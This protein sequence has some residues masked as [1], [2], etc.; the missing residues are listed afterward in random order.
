MGKKLGVMSGHKFDPENAKRLDHPERRAM[1]APERVI[2][3]IRPE[4][5]Q[6]WAEIGCGNGFF[7]GPLAAKARKVHALDISEEMLDKLRTNLTEWGV[8]NVEPA[9]SA[10]NTLPLPDDSVDGVLMAFVAHEF[11]ELVKAF[12]EAG[13]VLKPAGTLAVVEF[14]K[15]E[16][17]GPPLEHR[18][19]PEEVEDWARR[20]GLV[21][22]RSWDWDRAIIG[23]AFTA[24][25]D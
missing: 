8:S 14:A 13:R 5:G 25:S 7:T 1:L 18:V 3:D 24:S 2:A 11:D 17:W 20:S 6:I 22:A 12:A 19:S 21:P 23:W 4:P 10:E 16:S 9:R 15:V